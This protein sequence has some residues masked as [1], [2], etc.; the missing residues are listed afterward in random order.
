[1]RILLNI[2]LALSVLMITGC[3]TFTNIPGPINLRD[4]HGS[5]QSITTN[6]KSALFDSGAFTD[7][8]IEV[9]T[10]MSVV[11]LSGFVKTIRQYDTAVKIASEAN[12]VKGVRNHLVIR[13]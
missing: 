6:V 8:T 1:M 12:G 11:T 5:N 13:K 4:N 3:Q 10:E 2:V 9:T 7:A